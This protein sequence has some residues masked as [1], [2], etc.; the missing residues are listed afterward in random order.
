M[1]VGRRRL[2][3]GLGA[4][5]ASV[6][7]LQSIPSSAGEAAF[8]RRL[9]FFYSPNDNGRE[10]FWRPA[11]EGSEFALPEAM[12]EMLQPLESF[13]DNLLVVGNMVMNTRDK[14]TGP[15][16]HVGMGHQLT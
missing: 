15:G 8:P 16:G 14:E 7:F 5:L 10:D 11:G 6:P 2:L 3:Q 4:S 1:Q 12:P 13:R 9:V